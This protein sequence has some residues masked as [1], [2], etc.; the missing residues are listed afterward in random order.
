M[1]E[2]FEFKRAMTD[3]QIRSNYR[4][5]KLRYVILKILIC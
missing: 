4:E 1:A 3:V 5:V 2:S